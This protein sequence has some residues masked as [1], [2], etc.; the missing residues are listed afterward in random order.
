MKSWSLPLACYSPHQL[1]QPMRG[2]MKC[3]CK[4]KVWH[5]SI[6]KNRVPANFSETSSCQVIHPPIRTATTPNQPENPSSSIWRSVPYLHGISESVDGRLNPN[7]VTIAHKLSYPLGSNH[8]HAK[9]PLPI[10]LSNPVHG[11][12]YYLHWTNRPLSR[13]K[14]KKAAGIGEVAL[15]KFVSRTILN[16]RRSH[17]QLARHLYLRTCLF[18]KGTWSN[19]SPTFGRAWRE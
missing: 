7:N 9:E 15:Y 1:F 19:R 13:N 18:P 8:G 2:S 16:R 3:A 11:L 17:F 14:A 12:W 10:N 4:L 5:V 6:Q